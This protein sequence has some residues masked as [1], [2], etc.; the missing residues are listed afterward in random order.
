MCIRDSCYP[1]RVQTEEDGTLL[2]TMDRHWVRC[3]RDENGALTRV[4][5]RSRFM[6]RFDRN[7]EA[8]VKAKLLHE[9]QSAAL[10]EVLGCSDREVVRMPWE[11]LRSRLSGLT[12][13]QALAAQKKLRD[14]GLL[15]DL[16]PIPRRV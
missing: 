12:R 5:L 1:D 11:E 15:C 13:P 2:L 16:L 3:E 4:I 14:N 9:N 6:V 7:A 10:G 8:A